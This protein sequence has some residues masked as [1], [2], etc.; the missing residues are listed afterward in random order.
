[1]MRF[2]HICLLLC[3]P[4]CVRAQETALKQLP[5][6]DIPLEK[7]AFKGGEKLTYVACYKWGLVNSD[8]GELSLSL[9]HHA[10]SAEPYFEVQGS[11]RSFSFF[12]ILFKVRDTYEGRFRARNISP[13]YFYRDIHEGKYTIQ[14]IFHFQPDYSVQMRSIRRDN[15]IKDTVIQGTPHTFDLMTLLYFARNIDMAAM[16]KG[17]V[18]PLSFVID[19]E[20]YN[21]QFRYEGVEQKKIQGM[22]TFRSHK[23]AASLVAGVVF[24]GKE[25]MYVWISADE[26]RIPLYMESP[27]IVGKVAVR[28][29]KYEGLMH[30][31]SSK[32]K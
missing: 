2:Y 22:G 29:S 21:L 26:N 17:D 24:S 7:L 23:F 25:E 4:L 27:I 8:V 10:N 6:H 15:N 18:Y 31:L 9:Q 3:L 5:T 28:L 12:D 14:N 20:L 32:I 30:P 1:M 19:S 16:K 13:L 11:V